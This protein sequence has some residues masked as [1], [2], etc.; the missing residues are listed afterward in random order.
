MFLCH[1]KYVFAG[2]RFQISGSGT[3]AGKKNVNSYYYSRSSKFTNQA[4]HTVQHVLLPT[5]LPRNLPFLVCRDVHLILNP[6]YDFLVVF[7]FFTPCITYHW[8]NG[9]SEGRCLKAK[10][11]IVWFFVCLFVFTF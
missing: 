1:S 10:D 5:I 11:D 9:T 6:S 4:P 2:P 7:F 8:I 3:P